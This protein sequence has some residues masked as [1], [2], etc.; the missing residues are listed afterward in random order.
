MTDDTSIGEELASKSVGK[1]L[2][3]G[4]FL[5]T[6]A[7]N[8]SFTDQDLLGRWTLMYFGFTHC[9]DICPEEL[10]K[11]GVAV[12]MIGGEE[13]LPIFISVDPARD[14]VEQ[15]RKYITGQSG[16]YVC[17]ARVW[18]PSLALFN[19][20]STDHV[21]LDFHPRMIGLTGDYDSIKQAC[22]SYRVYFSTPPD[23]KPTDDY[24]VDH[25]SVS[26][27]LGVQMETKG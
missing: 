3:G 24:L 4:P 8:Q 22:K 11:M 1:P 9:P 5:L 13:V 15:V 19:W 16:L 6:T 20:T 25:R 12:D 18:I 7:Q 27:S 26:L 2:I 17:T 21:H 23:A 10:D 14:S